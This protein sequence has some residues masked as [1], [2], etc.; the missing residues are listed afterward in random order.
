MPRSPAWNESFHIGRD[1]GTFLLSRDYI[2][3]GLMYGYIKIRFYPPERT[4]T[5][6][7]IQLRKFLY[8]IFR[9]VIPLTVKKKIIVVHRG[10]IPKDKLVI[11]VST[12]EFREDAEATYIAAGRSAYILNGSVSII[13]AKATGADIVAFASVRTE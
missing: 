7:G 3:T 10:N 4:I 6:F 1:D 5:P 12:H 11:F 9:A 8:P 2:Y 13:I